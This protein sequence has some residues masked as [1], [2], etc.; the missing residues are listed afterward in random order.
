M[1]ADGYDAVA[2]EYTTKFVGELADKPF[3]RELL[4]GFDE[5][6][7][8]IGPVC[9]LGC[10]PGQVARHLREL[11]AD[12]FGIDG[13]AAMVAEARKCH[14][15]LNFVQGDMRSLPLSS[16]SLGGIA[17]FYSAIHLSLEE[18]TGALS[19]WGRVI[20]AEGSLLLSYHVGSQVVH[21]D[22]WWDCPVDLDFH[23]F[24]PNEMDEL[25]RAS[26]FRIQ[27]HWQRA[28]YEFEHPSIRGYIL[29]TR[30]SH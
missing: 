4:R 29:G 3:D 21:F 22:N 14:P 10:G 8:P 2:K 28:P 5:I 26:K 6:T 23:F 13:S 18:L 16:G 7:G 27:N 12:A 20:R 30:L 25:I 11:G 15:G 24:Q 19:E 9:D 1:K 17:A